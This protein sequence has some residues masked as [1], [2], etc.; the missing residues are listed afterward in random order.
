MRKLFRS[1]CVF[2]IPVLLLI[3]ILAVYGNIALP[4]KACT[5][6]NK[7]R[8]KKIYT[9]EFSGEKI[10]PVSA[11]EVGS[12][13][14]LA[15]IRLF[16]SIPIKEVEINKTARRYVI[17]GGELV[18]IRLKTKGV[19]VVGFQTFLSDNRSVCPA[20]EADL[21]EGDIIVSLDNE[22]ITTNEDLTNAFES[23]GGIPLTAVIERDGE[24]KQIPITPRLSDV[25]G[26][27]KCGLWVR[28]CTSGIGTLSYRDLKN[29]T[30]ATLGH[31]IF[32][33]DTKELIPSSEGEMYSASATGIKKGTKGCAG[34]LHGLIGETDY[35]TVRMNSDRGVFG[36]VSRIDDVSGLIPVAYANEVK[37]GKAQ[38]ISSVNNNEKQYYDIEI[39]SIHYADK[40]NIKNMTIRVTDP[41]LL[42]LTGG[43]IQGMSG[44]PIIQNGM[45]IGAVT[46][47]FLND[48]KKGYAIFAENMFD[49]SDSLSLSEAA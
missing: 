17:P 30:I 38:I 41:E 34:E 23:S 8:Y 21:K 45:L 19:L 33:A 22:E 42:E 29:G 5:V 47:V 48:P 16:G 13:T 18:G 11:A 28:D 37:T 1:I 43:I 2:L 31:G 24:E 39:E 20:R 10:R 7:I 9:A 40:E 14:H 32:D 36:N 6:K 4:D 35:G 49:L 46:H 12:T 25:T 15:D 27:Y 3:G 26:L 44:S